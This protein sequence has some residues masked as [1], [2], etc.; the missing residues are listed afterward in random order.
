MLSE[1]TVGPKTD[2]LLSWGHDLDGCVFID[3]EK[4]FDGSGCHVP[5]CCPGQHNLSSQRQRMFVSVVAE[6]WQG[7]WRA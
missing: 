3:L 1:S 4:A 2:P 6:V 7:V 5:D